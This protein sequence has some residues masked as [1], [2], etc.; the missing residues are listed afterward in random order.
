MASHRSSL[1]FLWLYLLY[2]NNAAFS[3]QVKESEPLK[4]EAACE[5]G[6]LPCDNGDCIPRIGWCNDQVEC[7]DASDEA[8]CFPLHPLATISDVK[9]NPCSKR[10]FTCD[11]GMCIPLSAHCDDMPDCRNREDEEDCW[12]DDFETENALEV[13]NQNMVN[14]TTISDTTIE[15]P[16]AIDDQDVTGVTDTQSVSGVTDVQTVLPITDVETTTAAY[17]PPITNEPT[18]PDSSNQESNPNS[19][20]SPPLSSEDNALVKGV[21]YLL[22]QR[23]SEWGWGESTARFATAL[24]LTNDSYFDSRSYEGHLTKKQLE[25]QLALDLMRVNSRPLRIDQLE[26][27]INALLATCSDPRN[28][29][30]VNL[31]KMLKVEVKYILARGLFV[32]PLAYLALCNADDLSDEYISRIKN[33]AYRRS[34]EPMWLDIQAIALL[35]IACRSKSNP[36][37]SEWKTMRED[38]AKNI[39]EWQQRDGSFGSMYS[40]GLALQALIAANVSATEHAQSRALAYLKMHQNWD[41][42]FGNELDNFYVLPTLNCKSLASIAEH[43]CKKRY[44]SATQNT[45]ATHRRKTQKKINVHYSLWIGGPKNE[46]HTLTLGIKPHTNFLEIM[47]LAQQVNSKYKFE[48]W[49]TD[50]GPVINS[51]GGRS[52]DVEKG[53]YWTLYR[54]VPIQFRPDVSNKTATISRLKLFGARRFIK[55]LRKLFP[56]DKEHLAFWLK[57][58]F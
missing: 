34:E 29:H 2:V 33:V 13:L 4:L 11:D 26:N 41:G 25:V 36:S 52:S 8:Y 15:T 31:V 1:V 45:E 18:T 27:Y 10:H 42:S 37:S 54:K 40:T 50:R 47:E 9:M 49:D 53:T 3:V 23:D 5:Y 48:V 43:R 16:L 38:V 6:Y 32:N 57:P 12:N 19:S 30:G 58:Y 46:I 7:A 28:F 55:D 22:Q 21:G 14:H 17:S 44:V 56:K 20:A 24:Y 35:T 39:T 51:V